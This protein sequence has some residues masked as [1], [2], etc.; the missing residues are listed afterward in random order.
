MTDNLVIQLEIS[1]ATIILRSQMATSV[2]WQGTDGWLLWRD[3]KVSVFSSLLY[4]L[5]LT[6]DFMATQDKTGLADDTLESLWSCQTHTLNLLWGHEAA[7]NAL[8]LPLFSRSLFCP[9]LMLLRLRR[10]L[11]PLLPRFTLVSV[12]CGLSVQGL[13]PCAFCCEAR[14]DPHRSVSRLHH[15]ALLVHR[16]LLPPPGTA[17]PSCAPP[18]HSTD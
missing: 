7:M 12:E 3:D 18:I 14:L 8:V 15:C 13:Q 4:V 11:R 1:S 5:N 17:G 6:T 9:L 16:L 2:L 10:E